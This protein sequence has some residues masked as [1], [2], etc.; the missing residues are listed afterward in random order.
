[1]AGDAYASFIVISWD[2]NKWNLHLK[3][4]E[5]LLNEKRERKEDRAITVNQSK[6]IH[7]EMVQKNLALFCKNWKYVSQ[8]FKNWPIYCKSRKCQKLKKKR[9][10]SLRL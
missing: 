9:K 2:Q 3:E 7:S 10:N 4:E 6:D 5:G 1:M 8:I